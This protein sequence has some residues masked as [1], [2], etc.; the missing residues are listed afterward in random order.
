MSKKLQLAK[1]H[2]FQLTKLHLLS[3]LLLILIIFIA[4]FTF[5]HPTKGA[6]QS[7]GG[8]KTQ[9]QG[10]FK[11]YTSQTLGISF[12]YASGPENQRVQTANIGDKVYLYIDYSKTGDPTTGKFVEILSKDPGESLIDAVKNRFLQ[13]YSPTDCLVIPA[14]LSTGGI[15]PA[16]QYAQITIPKVQ[17]NNMRKQLADEKACPSPYTFNG[18]TGTSYFMMDPKHQDKYVFFNLGQDNFWGTQPNSNSVGLTW[19]QTLQFLGN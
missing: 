10:E 9:L 8:V 12:D 3:L 13:G 6:L 14:H 15:N 1:K 5:K 16:Y 11:T 4:G 7:S 19:D 18:R 2:F 17:A